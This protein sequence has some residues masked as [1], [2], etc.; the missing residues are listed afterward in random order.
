MDCNDV[1][2]V[3]SYSEAEIGDKEEERIWTV[4]A[5]CKAFV[6]HAWRQRR[7]RTT[8]GPCS[9]S[10]LETKHR[11]LADAG[12]LPRE[13]FLPWVVPRGLVQ[14]RMSSLS[15]KV[16]PYTTCRTHKS[17]CLVFGF[18]L[19]QCVVMGR[20]IHRPSMEHLFT[21]SMKVIAQ[22]RSPSLLHRRGGCFDRHLHPSPSHWGR[23]RGARGP[24][25][26]RNTR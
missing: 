5:T 3:L 9:D 11:E 18:L 1:H 22:A 13:S 26:A 15:K 21:S 14:V 12:S 7:G 4:P 19:P 2:G 20:C 16:L 8:Y 24:E 23:T 25:L 10:L 17:S 6:S